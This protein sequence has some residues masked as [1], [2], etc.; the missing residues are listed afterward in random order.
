MG[1]HVIPE[2]F[3]LGA[4]HECFDADGGLKDA[5]VE[6]AVR[7]VGAALAEM[8]ARI[9]ASDRSSLAA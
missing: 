9:G 2:S 5:N 4:A 1:V 7:G 8:L 3:A 6:R